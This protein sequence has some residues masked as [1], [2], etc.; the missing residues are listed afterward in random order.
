MP[1]LF[2]EIFPSIPPIYSIIFFAIFF[3]SINL[4][5]IELTKVAAAEAYGK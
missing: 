2:Y 3:N 1:I 4:L 5:L